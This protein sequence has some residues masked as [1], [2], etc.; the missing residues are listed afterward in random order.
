MRQK[1][2]DGRTIVMDLKVLYY[3]SD[4]GK[5]ELVPIVTYLY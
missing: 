1:L 4:L 5:F 3:F 2:G